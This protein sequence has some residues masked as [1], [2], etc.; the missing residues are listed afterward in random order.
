MKTLQAPATDQQILD[1]AREWTN[2]LARDDYE[3]AFEITAHDPYYNWSPETMRIVVQNYGS[4]DPMADGS[5]YRVT[6]LDDATGDTVP[7]HEVD[8][9]TYPRAISNKKELTVGHVWFDLPLNGE[10]SDLTAT[11]EI[12]RSGDLLHLVLNDIHVH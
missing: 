1:I 3:S 12:R 9:M 8:W 11:F 5:V 4:I 2:A 6:S 7:E 10:W